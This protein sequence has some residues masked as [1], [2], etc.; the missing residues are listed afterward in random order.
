MEKFTQKFFITNTFPEFSLN[1]KVTVFY[2]SSSALGY[3]L[4]SRD[5]LLMVLSLMQIIWLYSL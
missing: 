3:G 4:W 1:F 2:N 5:T